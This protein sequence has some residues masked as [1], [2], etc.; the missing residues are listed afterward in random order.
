MQLHSATA[1]LGAGNSESALE[2]LTRLVRAHPERTDVLHRYGVVLSRTG[3][4]AE[5]AGVLQKVVALTP[6]S[7]D[8]ASDH[9]NI[10]LNLERN[11]EALE[12]LLI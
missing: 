5:A 11:D 1:M 7:I 6:G 9:A 12:V 3:R 2:L 8:A 4:D 10:L